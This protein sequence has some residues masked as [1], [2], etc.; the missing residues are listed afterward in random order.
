MIRATVEKEKNLMRKQIVIATLVVAG[1]AVGCGKKEEPAPAPAPAPV[2]I[3]APTAVPTP[4]ALAVGN[5]TLGN[6]V[7]ADKKVATPAETFGVKDKVFASVE[8]TGQGHAKLRALWSY[9]KGDKTAKVDE[10]SLAVNAAGPAVHEFHVSKPSG[11]PKGDY[12]VEIFLN[13]AAAAGASKTF[14]IQ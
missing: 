2:V 12:K 7:G 5:V 9:M 14:K 13:D 6:S 4:A 3:E 11:W 1:L 10:T 8:T